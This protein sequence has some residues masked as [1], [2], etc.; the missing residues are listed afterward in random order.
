MPSGSHR[1]APTELGSP[2]PGQTGVRDVEASRPEILNRRLDGK[3]D[4]VDAEA[5]ARAVL[6]GRVVAI[7]KSGDDPVE[8]FRAREIAPRP[9]THD[10]TEAIN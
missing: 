2:L 7:P 4:F 10:R 8:K 6:P 1:L 9:V 3:D 5:A